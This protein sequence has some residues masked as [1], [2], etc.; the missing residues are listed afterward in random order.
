MCKRSNMNAVREDVGEDMAVIEV[1]EEAVE[2]RFKWRWKIRVAIPDGRSRNKKKK[3]FVL[4]AVD[5]QAYRVLESHIFLLK[6]HR[7]WN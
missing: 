2:D 3:N 5:V 4:I 7:Y 1:T 6:W